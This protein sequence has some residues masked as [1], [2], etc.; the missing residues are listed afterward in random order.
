MFT[1]DAPGAGTDPGTGTFASRIS[2]RNVAV[3]TLLDAHGVAH[4]WYGK[5]TP[6]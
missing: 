3:G 1:F 5:P 2:N 6:K 4:G